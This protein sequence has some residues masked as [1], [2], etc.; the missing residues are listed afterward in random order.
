MERPFWA[1]WMQACAV[2]T[3]VVA[4]PGLVVPLLADVQPGSGLLSWL[5]GVPSTFIVWLPAMLV[6]SA[7][8]VQV[9]RSYGSR[10]SWVAGAVLGAVG[11]LVWLFV[12]AAFVLSSAT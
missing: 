11:S 5:V 4:A 2:G 10:R 1:D 7:A 6:L 3:V 12:A 9:A 8:G